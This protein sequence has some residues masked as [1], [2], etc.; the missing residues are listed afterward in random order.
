MKRSNSALLSTLGATM[1]LSIVLGSSSAFAA[2]PVA[3]EFSALWWS[4]NSSIDTTSEGSSAGGGRAELW[5]IDKVGVAGSTF[6]ANP[7][8]VM[9]ANDMRWSQADVKWRWMSLSKNN[10]FATGLGWERLSIDGFDN[11]VSSGPRV[12]VEGGS[13]S[14]ASSTSTAGARGCRGSRTSGLRFCR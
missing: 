13:G 9:S 8:G 7:G 10:F 6:A 1:A 4:S 5:F 11:N 12:V 14:S 2:G 3:G